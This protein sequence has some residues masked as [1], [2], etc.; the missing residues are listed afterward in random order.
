MTVG[1]L[2]RMKRDTIALTEINYGVSVNYPY[3]KS[4][5]GYGER[6]PPSFPSPS[7]AA[8]TLSLKL[9]DVV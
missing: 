9:A 3:I 2:S 8:T 5:S 6:R 7:T 1:W 4:F